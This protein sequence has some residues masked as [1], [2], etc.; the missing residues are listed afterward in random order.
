MTVAMGARCQRHPQ[1]ERGNDGACL[2]GLG[3]HELSQL[4]FSH[5]F[6]PTDGV[7]CAGDL[8]TLKLAWISS[9]LPDQFR[10]F[11]KEIT[12]KLPR[13]LQFGPNLNLAQ[14]LKPLNHY[15]LS[16]H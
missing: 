9:A 13:V 1:L 4:R 15:A 12:L 2:L 11:C 16:V 10:S 7:V 14:S 8:I 5:L 6:K 3:I